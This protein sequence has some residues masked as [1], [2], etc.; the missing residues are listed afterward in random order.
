MALLEDKAGGLVV[1]G[2]VASN[3]YLR[4][5]YVHIHPFFLRLIIRLEQTMLKL[6]PKSP[7]TLYFPPIQLCT[8]KSTIIFAVDEADKADNAAMIAWTAVLRIQANPGLLEGEGE[9][10]DLPLRT[11]WS[12]E[13]LY[14]DLDTV[15]R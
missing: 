6:N 11:K 12:L 5:M 1:S 13:T 9:G 8:G 2:G 3:Q 15:K 7:T 4:K 10:Y 14:D